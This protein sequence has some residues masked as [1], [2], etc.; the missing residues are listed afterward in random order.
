MF[1]M[2]LLDPSTLMGILLCMYDQWQERIRV[3]EGKLARL[4]QRIPTLHIEKIRTIMQELV[5]GIPLTWIHLMRRVAR[6]VLVYIRVAEAAAAEEAEEAREQDD[7][8]D[9]C[10]QGGQDDHGG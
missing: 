7:Q 5:V 3:L 6:V 10:D 1:K 8:D 2:Q 9:Q 4:T